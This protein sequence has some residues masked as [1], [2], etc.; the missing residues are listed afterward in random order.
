M[1]AGWK[2]RLPLI[3]FGKT[4]R[5]TAFEESSAISF[6]HVEF[7]CL[8]G[9]GEYAVGFM[10]LEFKRKVLLRDR[11]FAD[12][13]VIWYLKSSNVIKSPRDLVWREMRGGP[14]TGA[15]SIPIRRRN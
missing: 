11:N 6:G 4:G 3:D 8:L 7:E 9:H 10:S 1:T 14:R 5:S 2:D 12:V 15:W 13:H